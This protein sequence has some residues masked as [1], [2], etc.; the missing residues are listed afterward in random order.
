MEEDC[1]LQLLLSS[2]HYSSKEQPFTFSSS[3][4]TWCCRESL[5]SHSSW[6]CRACC[7]LAEA[8][9]RSHLASHWDSSSAWITDSCPWHKRDHQEHTHTHR[10][11]VC[12]RDESPGLDTHRQ[13]AAPVLPLAPTHTSHFSSS[14]KP[15]GWPEG[16]AQISDLLAYFSITFHSSQ[17]P[18][19][20][21]YYNLK[22]VLV[23]SSV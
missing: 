22:L 3:W 21:L 17:V 2:A 16:L 4:A 20:S 12:T 1:W 6:H 7:S 5:C 14:H 13:S 23:L 10:I 8:R 9:A 11:C 15:P 18:Y 19:S